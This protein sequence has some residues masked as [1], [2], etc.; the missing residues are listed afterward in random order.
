MKFLRIFS[1][2][3][4]STGSIFGQS[5]SNYMSITG[6]GVYKN[7]SEGIIILSDFSKKGILI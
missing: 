3:I 1:L 2:M 4:L 6:G 5:I 7:N